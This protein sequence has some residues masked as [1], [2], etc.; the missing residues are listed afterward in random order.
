MSKVQTKTTNQ[1][2]PDKMVWWKSPTAER[3]IWGRIVIVKGGRCWV[4]FLIKGSEVFHWCPKDEL[5]LMAHAN[6]FGGK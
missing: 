3:R 6:T 4:R 5:E 2:S 1:F